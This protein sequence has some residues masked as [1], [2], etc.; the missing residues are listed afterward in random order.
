MDLKNKLLDNYLKQQQ[1][2][3]AQQQQQMG[4]AQQQHQMAIAQHQGVN[5]AQ[6][7]GVS[8]AQHQGVSHALVPATDN[9]N[10]TLEEFKEYVRKWFEL[11]NVIKKA[12]EAI[13]ERKI[14]RDKLS[15]MISKF[16]CKYDIE[17]LNTKEGRIR[18]KVSHVKAPIN[19]KVIK[20]K[21]TDYFKHDES[22]QQEIM[23]K[24][25]EE[26]DVVQKVSL[27][28]LKIT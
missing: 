5:H 25:Y 22:K 21:I 14:A 17:D 16:M 8:H 2:A 27:R 13:K 28:R 24:I 9:E 20:E 7:Q 11:D 10:I 26:R 15:M 18:C 1:M 3:Q 19:Q 6:H 4:Q 23:T 12:Q